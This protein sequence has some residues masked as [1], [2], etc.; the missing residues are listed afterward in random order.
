MPEPSEQPPE[1]VG[2]DLEAIRERVKAGASGK[3][4]GSVHIDRAAL[5]AEV[6]RLRAAL[7]ADPMM[8]MMEAE[9]AILALQEENERLRAALVQPTPDGL[10][11]DIGKYI[12]CFDCATTQGGQ[13]QPGAMLP[14][15]TCGAATMRERLRAALHEASGGEGT[16]S[17]L[18]EWQ[19]LTSTAAPEYAYDLSR[20]T[21]EY[22]ATLPP[23]PQEPGK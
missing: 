11:A 17:L 18:R 4:R 19:A 22:L 9:R 21:R 6:D 16:V 3:Y 15:C 12:R 20:R 7:R 14:A 2:M 5:L 23:P 10:L 8:L 1:G 13:A